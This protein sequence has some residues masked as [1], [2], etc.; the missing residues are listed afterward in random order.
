MTVDSLRQNLMGDL[1]ALATTAAP[2]Q[3]AGAS[4]PLLATA[5]LERWTE[6]HRAYHDTTHLAECLA[7]YDWVTAGIP[8]FE[9]LTGRVAL[10]YHDAVYLPGRADNEEA[11]AALAET[12]LASLRVA[13]GFIAEVARL[14]RETAA[15]DL[16]AAGAASAW[17][18]DADLWILA[19]PGPRFDDYCAQ[20]RAEY[21]VVPDAA[22]RQGR[23]AILSALVN[24][25]HLYAEPLPR[26]RWEAAARANVARELAR[27]A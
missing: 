3:E 18:H 27:L 23:A 6:P 8:A 1:N 15:H 14:I 16:P 4:V 25:P 22:Y 12:D 20:V 7:A 13:P 21:A 5:L 26:A 24:R 2:G 10:W 19:A 11:S 17:V 9:R